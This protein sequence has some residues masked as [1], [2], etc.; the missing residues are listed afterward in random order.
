MKTYLTQEKNRQ[1]LTHKMRKNID[2]EYIKIMKS[3]YCKSFLI[4]KYIR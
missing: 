4:K 2:A 1:V 3:N